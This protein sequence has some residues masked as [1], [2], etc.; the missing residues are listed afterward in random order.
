MEAGA[1]AEGHPGCP[2]GRDRDT[3]CAGEAQTHL[4]LNPLRDMKDKKEFYRYISSKGRLEKTWAFCSR[5][6]G[7]W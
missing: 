7:L 3:E 2:R 6:Q 1:G 4:E 5:G